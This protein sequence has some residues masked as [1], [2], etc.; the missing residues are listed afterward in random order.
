MSYAVTKKKDRI[1]KGFVAGYVILSLIDLGQT[2]YGLSIGF[3]EGNS[4]VKPIE[5][6]FLLLSTIKIIGIVLVVLLYNQLWTKH[7]KFH[8][9]IIALTKVIFGLQLLVVIWN[10]LVLVVG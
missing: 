2:L 6:N 10:T 5:D 9:I 4:I 1:F 7:T 8:K 3:E